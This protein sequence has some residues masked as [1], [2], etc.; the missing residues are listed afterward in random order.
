VNKE[1]IYL[2]LS[3]VLPVIFS[4]LVISY[5]SRE[6][7]AKSSIFFLFST[8]EPYIILVLIFWFLYWR[9]PTRIIRKTIIKL[10]LYNIPGQTL[11][12]GFV[13]KTEVRDFLNLSLIN[14]VLL[15]ILGSLLYLYLWVLLVYLADRYVFN[16]E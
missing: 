12:W 11:Y 13:L 15:L 2:L 4:L 3:P 8:G 16:Q 1:R 5:G 14:T 6:L 7:I 9:K 10:P